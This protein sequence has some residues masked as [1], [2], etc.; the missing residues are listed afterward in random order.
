MID[1]MLKAHVII[2]EK[3]YRDFIIIP[4]VPYVYRIGQIQYYA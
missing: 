2:L 1:C 3:E 4:V